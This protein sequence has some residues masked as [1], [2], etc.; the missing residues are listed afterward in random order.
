[1]IELTNKKHLDSLPNSRVK[2]LN[3]LKKAN[4]HNEILLGKIEEY[5]PKTLQLDM[6]GHCESVKF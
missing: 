5:K 6:L 3:D 2:K 4:S 1:M